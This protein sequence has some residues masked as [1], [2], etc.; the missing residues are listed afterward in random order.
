V[1]GRAHIHAPL[2][3]TTPIFFSE[4]YGMQIFYR[5]LKKNEGEKTIYEPIHNRQAV[6]KTA[7]LQNTQKIIPVSLKL[8]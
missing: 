7:P 6:A 3:G 2:R 1:P 4:E 8:S 5:D